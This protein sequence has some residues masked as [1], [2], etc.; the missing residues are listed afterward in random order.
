MELEGSRKVALS[1]MLDPFE[2]L[3]NESRGY[4]KVTHE[5]TGENETGSKQDGS[6]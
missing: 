5:L 6:K 1:E 3:V 4:V 2:V